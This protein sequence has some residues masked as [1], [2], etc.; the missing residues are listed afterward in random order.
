MTSCL[1]IFFILNTVESQLMATGAFEVSLNDQ[2]MWSKL[3]AGR[4][5]SLH[6]LFDMIDQS[7]KMT[8]VNFE[9]TMNA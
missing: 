1:M 2:R 8:S 4:L 6:E 5:P 9:D 7:T 3:E